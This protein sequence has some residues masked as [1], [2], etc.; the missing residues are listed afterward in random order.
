MVVGVIGRASAFA[1]V[2]ITQDENSHDDTVMEP[3]PLT[4]DSRPEVF[5][6]KIIHLYEALFKVRAQPGAR[7]PHPASAK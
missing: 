1:T 3:S 5:Q 4:Q 2:D 7:R 6:P